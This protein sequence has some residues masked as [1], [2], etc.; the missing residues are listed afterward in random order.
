MTAVFSWGLKNHVS[1]GLWW[2][3]PWCL[4]CC[5]LWDTGRH[6]AFGWSS[7]WGGS[8]GCGWE[9]ALPEVVVGF[10]VKAYIH[11]LGSN[12]LRMVM[13][14]KY[15]AFRRWLDTPS[16]SSDVRWAR[17]PRDIDVCLCILGST[18]L[19]HAFCVSRKPF[20]LDSRTENVH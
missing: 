19:F 1:S 20:V 15:F 10:R 8:P 12:H 5:Y 14:P 4:N 18:F 13:E 2:F 7:S 6:S 11:Y 16:S 17:I 9:N 3:N